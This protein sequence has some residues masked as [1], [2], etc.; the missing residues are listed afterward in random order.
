M[1]SSKARTEA[2]TQVARIVGQNT[3]R[4]R[5]QQRL[6]GRE[7]AKKI[8]SNGRRM[9]HAALSRIELGYHSNGARR[10][11]TVD[12]LSWIAEALGVQPVALLAL[13]ACDTC[14]DVPPAGFACRSCGAE[15]P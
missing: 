6:S 1:T 14:G 13:P 11:V 7:L 9:D 3:R 10:A 5:E 8:Q 2:D 4:L 15:T 12:E